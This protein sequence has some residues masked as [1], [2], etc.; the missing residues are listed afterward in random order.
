MSKL[1]SGLKCT[2]LGTKHCG[3]CQSES[4]CSVECQRANWKYH[5]I[6]CGKKL[7]S[8]MELDAFL[9]N[10]ANKDLDLANREGRT[11]RW[12]EE[13]ILFVENQLRDQV[14]GEFYRRL[15]YGDII[16]NDWGLFNL[17]NELTQCYIRQN[18]AAT[19]EIALGYAT[20]TR[21][22]LEMR[23]SD[24]D[25]RWMFFRSIHR[26]NTQLGFI[27]R[28]TM[29][30]KEA[31][32]R[33][34][35][36]LDAARLFVDDKN[37]G[38]TVWS[39][40][41]SLIQALNNVAR[42]QNLLKSGEG[43]KYAEEAYTLASNQYGPEHPRVQSAAT[44]LIDCCVATGNIVDAERF[45]RIN[46]E[47]LNDL[48]SNTDRKSRVFANAKIQLAVIW[49]ST[50]SEQRDGG[51]EAAEEAEALAREA[52]DIIEAMERGENAVVSVTNFLSNSYA[53]LAEVMVARGEKYSEVEK[54]YLRALSLTSDCRAGV[55]PRVE[56]SLTRCK[57]L[58][59]LGDFYFNSAALDNRSL[60]K[61]KYAYE[62]SVII[63][64][65]LYSSDDQ[66]LL[67]C[68]FRLSSVNMMISCNAEDV[69]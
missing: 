11:I 22:R 54:I 68:I 30:Y 41:D 59:G 44:C 24:V 1:C 40:D 45:A 32:D 47:C 60:E 23:R 17:R 16:K 52:C 65:A 50:R 27:L 53:I 61:A 46:Y 43:A 64:T 31:L 51:S 19:Y 26:V 49:L 10:K 37:K 15:K 38:E 12:L 33:M 36:A 13:T 3:A 7:L 14:P 9:I 20:E 35:E 2:G 34:Q 57:V 8:G 18:T 29:R 66:R 55:V 63:A 42:L 4:Y 6:A 28:H 21:A 25:H 58:N 62:E 5:K 67:D 69:S 39:D 56:S 48:N